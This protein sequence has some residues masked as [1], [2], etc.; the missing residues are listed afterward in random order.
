ME[1]YTWQIDFVGTILAVVIAR[2]HSPPCGVQ[3]SM[4]MK[5]NEASDEQKWLWERSLSLFYNGYSLVFHVF[6]AECPDIN[7][8][9]CIDITFRSIKLLV[10]Y[11]QNLQFV[12][13]T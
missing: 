13:N 8:F 5:Q 1:I 11:C 3:F 4:L 6:S 7:Y 10:W 2:R 9:R 12:E